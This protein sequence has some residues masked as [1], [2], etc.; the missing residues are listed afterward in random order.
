M[1]APLP[2]FQPQ[3]WEHLGPWVRLWGIT[4]AQLPPT[5]ETTPD[6]LAAFFLSLLSEADP[7]L[8]SMSP[9]SG[10]QRYGG[11]DYPWHAGGSKKLAGSAAKVDLWKRHVTK[12]ILQRI[13][14]RG[15][16]EGSMP[17]CPAADRVAGGGETWVLRRSVHADA[18]AEGTAS[19]AEFVD[20]IR[21]RH[22]ETEDAFTPTVLAH[23]E[24]MGW[25]CE[26]VEVADGGLTWGR[27]AMK[28]L[29]VKHKI[30]PP[31]NNR[32]FTVLQFTCAALP[33]DEKKEFL[34]VSVPIADWKTAPQAEIAKEKGVVLGA[35]VSI[36]RVRKMDDGNIEWIM[37][38]ASDAKGVLPGWIQNMSVPGQ[39]AKDVP[40]FFSWLA[41]E[42]SHTGHGATSV[43]QKANGENGQSTQADKTRGAAPAALQ[44]EAVPE[45]TATILGS[46][47]KSPTS[48]A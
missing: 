45:A 13:A 47:R 25:D 23:R 35:Y 4:H 19:W 9:R 30:P 36:E 16:L 37:A 38:T 18:P 17:N 26:G 6:G 1:P 22:A 14:A 8:D 21:D 39:I 7:F 40:M 34:V 3:N 20:C 29:E 42:R 2:G 24:A 27:F 11:I 5:T 41:G 48:K 10:V 32:V 46:E 43:Q 33:E 28:L 12:E 31:L 15:G 44:T